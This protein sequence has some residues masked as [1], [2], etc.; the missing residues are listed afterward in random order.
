ML[1]KGNAQITGR[2]FKKPLGILEKGA[3]ADVIVLDYNPLTPMNARN[4]NSHILFGMSGRNTVTT[5]ANGK[6]LM[7][8]RILIDLDEEKIMADCRQA[9]SMLEKSINKI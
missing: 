2:Y 4:I 9:A 6:I 7:K 1:F 5:I 8:D 3:Y